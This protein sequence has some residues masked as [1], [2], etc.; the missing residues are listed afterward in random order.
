MSG[1]KSNRDRKTPVENGHLASSALGLQGMRK[2]D[3]VERNERQHRLLAILIEL[4][5]L[6]KCLFDFGVHPPACQ[7]IL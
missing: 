6:G 1:E 2:R 5:V 7:G 3:E 4:L